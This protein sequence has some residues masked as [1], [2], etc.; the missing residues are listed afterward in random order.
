MIAINKR[1]IRMG[2]R[3][4][5]YKRLTQQLGEILPSKV[6]SFF[7]LNLSMYNSRTEFPCF[8]LFPPAADSS[9][10]ETAWLHTQNQLTIFC[11]QTGGY[12]RQHSQLLQCSV[13]CVLGHGGYARQQQQSTTSDSVDSSHCCSLFSRLALFLFVESSKQVLQRTTTMNSVKTYR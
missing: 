2:A 5:M 12:C 9:Q 11:I 13:K 7:Y 6:F 3:S 10:E 4:R 8:S 1:S